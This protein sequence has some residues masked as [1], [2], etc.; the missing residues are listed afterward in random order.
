[1][2]CK[3]ERIPGKNI[4][5]L[6]PLLFLTSWLSSHSSDGKRMPIKYVTTIAN[7]TNSWW[8]APKMPV[9]FLGVISPTTHVKFDQLRYTVCWSDAWIQ[10]DRESEQHPSKGKEGYP[11][12]FMINVHWVKNW[13]L[14]NKGIPLQRKSLRLK[15]QHKQIRFVFFHISSISIVRMTTYYY[16]W[17]QSSDHCSNWD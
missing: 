15:T 16:A 14:Q 9:Y 7:V 1:M 13:D 2:T 4:A 10:T 3:S 8:H 12:C 5:T 11:C 6:H 17:G